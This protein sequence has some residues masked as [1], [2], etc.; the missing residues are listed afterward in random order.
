LANGIVCIVHPLI[1]LSIHSQAIQR[2]I[3]TGSLYT[4]IAIDRVGHRSHIAYIVIAIAHDRRG[5][6]RS[7]FVTDGQHPTIKV[8]G[9]TVGAVWIGDLGQFACG[10]VGTGNIARQITKSIDPLILSAAIEFDIGKID[11][12]NAGGTD[13]TD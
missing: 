5:K 13:R 9:I 10:V 8:I 11:I 7:P 1:T 3:L 4:K 2:I 6:I 12:R